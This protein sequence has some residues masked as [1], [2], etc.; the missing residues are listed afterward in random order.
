[1]GTKAPLQGSFFPRDRTD[2]KPCGRAQ[3][4]HHNHAY[5]SH[6]EPHTGIHDNAP[7]SPAPGPHSRFA[8]NLLNVCTGIAA[9]SKKPVGHLPRWHTMAVWAK[10]Q[11]ETLFTVVGPAWGAPAIANHRPFLTGFGA[12]YFGTF[13]APVSQDVTQPS[14]SQLSVLEKPCTCSGA[15]GRAVRLQTRRSISTATSVILKQ[16]TSGL[17]HLNRPLQRSKF[18]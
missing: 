11:E 18:T 17:M 15:S 16:C 13:S 6:R 5:T 4:V 14:R 7:L 12:K 9:W 2:K 10:A 1:M 3:I 8:A